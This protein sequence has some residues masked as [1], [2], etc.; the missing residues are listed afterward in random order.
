[1]CED[2]MARPPA[3]LYVQWLASQKCP[4]GERVSVIETDLPIAPVGL[5]SK[6]AA[7]PAVRVDRVAAA[8]LAGFVGVRPYP[9]ALGKDWHIDKGGSRR[10][11]SPSQDLWALL[12]NT[13][14]PHVAA[15]FSFAV[16]LRNRL[17]A[18]WL[19]PRQWAELL[20]IAKMMYKVVGGKHG[21]RQGDS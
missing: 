3:K 8:Q 14:A 5:C 2:F 4:C 10:G 19:T 11:R 15:A 12:R 1:M 17:P 18:S 7:N 9:P 21:T 6:C 20:E 16:S 13:E